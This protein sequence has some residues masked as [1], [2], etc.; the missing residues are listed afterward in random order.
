MVRIEEEL[1]SETPQKTR[2]RSRKRLE[3]EARQALDVVQQADTAPPSPEH[4]SAPVDKE[5]ER[6]GH[7]FVRYADDCNIYV[8]TER[9]GKRVMSGV[10]RFIEKTLKLKVI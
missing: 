8:R 3:G 6:R 1:V 2:K 10:K 7:R 9:A 4:P 5:L